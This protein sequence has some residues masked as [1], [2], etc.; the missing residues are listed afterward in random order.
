MP[1]TKVQSTGITDSAVTTAKIN[2]DAVTDA[3]IAD[4]AV[5]TAAIN[6][7][8]ITSDKIADNAVV[9]A[10]IN[11]DAIT[12]AKIADDAINSEHYTDAS[13]DTAHIG[14]SQVTAAKT[15]GVGGLQEYDQWRTNSNAEFN[16][17]GRH[18]VTANWE[19]DDNGEFEKIGTG[20]SESSGVFS[21]PSTGKYE[22]TWFARYTN[23]EGSTNRAMVYIFPEISVTTNNSAYGVRAGGSISNDDAGAEYYMGC[24]VTFLFDV[25]NTSTHKFKVGMYQAN[26]TTVKGDTNTQYS[27][28][29]VKKI[30]DT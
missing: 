13:I 14:D 29:F 24:Q 16:G 3:K 15:S 21:F 25:T 22:I 8:A 9:T 30:G 4:N 26:G 27:Y 20:L 19:R 7:D 17:S 11:A 23:R 1:L 18:Y 10:A 28:I 2:A 12:G 6:A 5:V